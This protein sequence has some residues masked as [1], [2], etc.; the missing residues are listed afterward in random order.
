MFVPRKY[1]KKKT[2]R[3]GE[4]FAFYN[5]KCRFFFTIT[6]DLFLKNPIVTSYLVVII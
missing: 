2:R 6:Y 4:F 1:H 5:T 3:N